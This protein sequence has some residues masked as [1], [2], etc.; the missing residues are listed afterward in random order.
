MYITISAKEIETRS[1]TMYH[2]GC[3]Q[4]MNDVD[5]ITSFHAAGA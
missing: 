3:P 5:V 2:K 4:P 1:S